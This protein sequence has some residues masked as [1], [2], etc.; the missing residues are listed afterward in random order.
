VAYT[1]SMQRV[2]FTEIPI[3][4]TMPSL[5]LFVIFLVSVGCAVAATYKPMKEILEMDIVV[6]LRLLF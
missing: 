6:L 2:L 3:P 1:M 5:L 4:F